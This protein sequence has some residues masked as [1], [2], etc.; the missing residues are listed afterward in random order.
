MV[1]GTWFA[2]AMAGLLAAGIVGFLPFN[3]PRA[4][5]FMGDVGSQFCGFILSE[6]AVVASRFDDVELSFLLVPML[7]MGVLYDVAFTLV[8]RLA[9]GKQITQPHRGHLY[10]VA[11]RSGMSPVAV[12]LVHWGF[13]VIGGVASLL[14]IEASSAAKP[15]VPL[16]VILPQAVW[17]GFVVARAR[18]ARITD[19]G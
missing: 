7:L 5:I 9:Q 6:L 10:Q 14:F 17:T 19:W 12:T 4:R 13:A 16:L 15:F 3:F 1:E 8:R 2:Y 18:I 11:H